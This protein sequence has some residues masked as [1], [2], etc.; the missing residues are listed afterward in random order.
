MVY[1]GSHEIFVHYLL[2]RE[3]EYSNISI[4]DEW[5]IRQ[6]I[7]GKVRGCV[8]IYG[9]RGWR[10]RTAGICARR[11]GAQQTAACSG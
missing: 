5:P 6:M 1:T 7:K 11:V 8:W 2:A 10:A 4:A 9:Y 3:S